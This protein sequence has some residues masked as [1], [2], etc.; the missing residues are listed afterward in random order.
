MIEQVGLTDAI[1][2]YPMQLSGGMRMRVSLARALVTRPRILLLDEPFAA[3][4]E[5]TRQRLDEQL[6]D[7][8]RQRHMT[9]LFVT[10][11]LSEATFLAQRVVVFSQRPGRVVADLPIDLPL[12]RPAEL[13][14]E[15][16]FNE[17]V[18]LLHQTLVREGA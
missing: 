16:H 18:G 13:R 9:V 3:L 7:L 12:L 15:R 2:R 5:L 4:D 10:H 8:W 1:K 17:L 14:V 6:Y 11:S